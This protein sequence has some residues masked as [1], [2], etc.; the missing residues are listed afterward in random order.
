[1][2]NAVFGKK[3]SIVRYDIIFRS[4]CGKLGVMNTKNSSWSG[5]P[6]L[7]ESYGAA[8]CRIDRRYHQSGDVNIKNSS[9]A[10]AGKAGD[11][12]RS[13]DRMGRMGTVPSTGGRRENG[14]VCTRPPWREEA[15]SGG[16]GGSVAMDLEDS[17]D[18]VDVWDQKDG[19]D[20]RDERLRLD[21]GQRLAG[22]AG[23]KQRQAAWALGRLRLAE[24]ASGR[25]RPVEAGYFKGVFLSLRTAT[26]GRVVP[27][28]ITGG[29]LPVGLGITRL[30]TL[31]HAWSGLI[32]LNTGIFLCPCGRPPADCHQ[33]AC[34]RGFLHTGVSTRAPQGHGRA[35]LGLGQQS[36]GEFTSLTTASYRLPPLLGEKFSRVF[37]HGHHA[38]G[39]P[40][41]LLKNCNRSSCGGA[42]ALTSLRLPYR[43]LRICAVGVPRHRIR[44]AHN[45]NSRSFSTGSKGRENLSKAPKGFGVHPACCGTGITEPKEIAPLARFY[46]ICYMGRKDTI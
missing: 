1:M 36:G 19:E 29:E 46:R 6:S 35:E 4:R 16:M 17:M 38:E 11:G 9:Y 14:G 41:S 37:A 32:T 28:G 43:S 8:L 44:R 33:G 18:A 20:Q 45:L 40:R 15:A 10:V 39:A 13:F 3:M 26:V 25:M 31:N 12:N 7:S 42:D 2:K 27:R 30:N 23:W 24:A 5:P 22:G 21:H 34:A